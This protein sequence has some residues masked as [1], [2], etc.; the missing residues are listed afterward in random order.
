MWIWALLAVIALYFRKTIYKSYL[1]MHTK[2]FILIESERNGGLDSY[3]FFRI[4]VENIPNNFFDK[5][6]IELDPPNLGGK[7]VL[8]PFTFHRFGKGLGE[9]DILKWSGMNVIDEIEMAIGKYAIYR[10]CKG[11]IFF[12][13]T[14]D[15][16]D[17]RYL[18]LLLD[19]FDL[20]LLIIQDQYRPIQECQEQMERICLDKNRYKIISD[21]TP[22]QD[23]DLED[24]K[25]GL[26]WIGIDIE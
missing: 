15:G 5:S 2:H 23:R 19:H 8:Y 6:I 26:R 16:T 4:L 25:S 1:L 22:R 3:H 13:P 17:S 12:F 7:K 20:P 18:L 9:G 11:I 24:F 10:K 21:P 14:F